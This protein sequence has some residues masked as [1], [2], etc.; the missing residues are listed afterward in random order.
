MSLI[1]IKVTEQFLWKEFGKHGAIT[2]ITIQLPKTEEEKRLRSSNTGTIEF[3]ERSSAEE[4]K[5]V[6][7]NHIFFGHAL[8]I[9]WSSAV[10]NQA[11]APVRI[12]CNLIE[13]YWRFYYTNNVV[14]D[15]LFVNI[16]Q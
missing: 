12:C 7:Q 14:A 13:L 2:A 15:L 8:K 10:F 3:V 6:L 16:M 5:Q 9:A 4:A 1:Y 11:P